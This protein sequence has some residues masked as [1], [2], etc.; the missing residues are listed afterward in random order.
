[1]PPMRPAASPPG[2]DARAVVAPP[3]A[4][5]VLGV[6]LALTDYE[7]TLDWVDD[8]VASGHRGYVC[9]AATHTVMAAAEDPELRSAVLRA[10]FTVP[11]G[12]PLVCGRRVGRDRRPQAGE[13][14]GADAPAARGAGADRRRRG[15][16]LPR[17]ARAAGAPV[18]AAAR[19]GVAGSR[20][21]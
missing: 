12:Q 18:D 10:D 17:R 3:P 16:R 5:P 21:A 19:P 15:V 13:V 2:A 6:P 20:P 7:R 8:A 9:V 11:D 4:A 1:M 14:D